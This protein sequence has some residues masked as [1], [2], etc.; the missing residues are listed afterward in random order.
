MDT[1]GPQILLQVFLIALNAFFA[2]TE[3]AVISL[4]AAKLRKMMEDGDKKAGKMLKMVEEPSG[5]LSTIQIGI[6]LAGFLGSA[7]AAENFSDPLVQWITQDLG[8]TA[9]ST[10]TLNTLSVVLITIVLSYFTL[11]FGEL[12]P[13][14]IAMQKPMAV[15]KIACGVIRAIATVMRPVIWFLSASTN[16]VLRLLRM[17]VEAEE[18]QV[19]EEEIRLM[20]D[21]GEEKG[22]GE[23]I[24]LEDMDT[25][26]SM[27]TLILRETQKTTN[28]TE[29][30]LNLAQSP[31]KPASGWAAAPADAKEFTLLL[32][33][34]LIRRPGLILK[35]ENGQ[36]DKVAI[37]KNKKE[38]DPIVTLGIGVM[39][40]EVVDE[41]IKGDNHYK[42]NRN[43]K[44]L[45]LDGDGSQLSMWISAAMDM[46]N[47]SVY[48]P[49]ELFKEITE[50]VG[51]PPPTS[52]GGCQDK[53]LITDCMLDN[54]Y[55]T[56]DWQ[57][58]AILHLIDNRE[59][60]VVF[61]H[62]HAIDLQ[63]H[64]FVKHLAEREFN[65]LPHEA[66]EKF[67]EDIY[68]QTDYYLGKF[69]HLLDEGWTILIFSDHAQ[70]A[71]KHDIPFLADCSG[72]NVRVM[73]ELGFT[74]LKTDAEGNEL[75]EIDWTKTRAI[76]SREEH[77]YINL[78]GRDPQGIV[79]PA[80]K[81]ELEEEIMTAL[82]GYRDAK[83]G[84]R[85]VAV[86]LRNRDA[87][88]LGQG[89]PEAGDICYWLAEGYN[90]DHADCLSTTLG[91]SDTSVSP[92]FIASGRGIKQGFYTD[93]YIR[94]I[95]FAPTVAILGGVR[96]PAQCEGAPAYQILEQDV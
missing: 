81:Y 70:V 88:L 2:A 87:V 40:R 96:M 27:Q 23:T 85:V 13:K 36:Y 17:K 67:M 7:F 43:M 9:I 54:W 80:D 22:K 64:M 28:F 18:E 6:T 73:Q 61:S 82:Y 65:R 93:R 5:F 32:S 16:A 71:P 94:Q 29:T 53:V 58:A 47:D 10:S 90:F 25:S 15:A 24:S 51:F 48:H 60:D 92:I 39:V 41:A 42:V 1:I 34:G 37:Y 8:F 68:V 72:V 20:V 69:L 30:P 26:M 63:S 86:A 57:S 49:R 75:P 11:I 46:E 3:I 89:G 95:D 44:V 31:I 55:V 19:S 74:V 52:Q 91:E 59:L 33:K 35:G 4:N 84:H 14:R 79:D 77:I 50:N 38:T 12:V 45:S 78:K 56:A 21:L 66:Y 62:F 76:A 83:T